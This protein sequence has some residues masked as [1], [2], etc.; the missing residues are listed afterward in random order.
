RKGE[1]DRRRVV[2]V[3]KE[4]LQA[5]RAQV[6]ERFEAGALGSDTVR[7]LSFL[8]DQLIRA[9]HDFVTTT[10]YP[11]ANPTSGEHMGVVAV[12]GYGRGQLTPCSDSDLLFLLR[13]KSPPHTAHGVQHLRY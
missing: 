13:H 8:M 1:P 5:G 4:A 6:R 3:L 2:E 7:A 11:L 12:G 10:I 9:L